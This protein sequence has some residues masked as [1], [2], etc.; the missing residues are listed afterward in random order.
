MILLWCWR[1][2]EVKNVFFDSYTEL[3]AKLALHVCCCCCYGTRAF[4]GAHSDMIHGE[5]ESKTNTATHTNT[6]W[7]KIERK[8]NRKAFKNARHDVGG[9][10]AGGLFKNAAD[11]FA[12]YFIQF[13]DFK[14]VS[15]AA[16][17]S[18]FSSFFILF[19]WVDSMCSA[20]PNTYYRMLVE[21]ALSFRDMHT[22]H[23]LDS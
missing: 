4:N 16:S 15:S 8:T 17:S 22:A 14:W 6:E 7:K 20:P 12:R 19:M 18:P 21:E 3:C 10:R 13:G 9:W 5:E 11:N 1:L 23:F 2:I